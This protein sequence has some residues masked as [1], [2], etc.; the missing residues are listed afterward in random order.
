MR[1][2]VI[3][4]TYT[5]AGLLAVFLL[6]HWLCSASLKYRGSTA[7]R[8]IVCFLFIS[9]LSIPVLGT[10]VSS[11]YYRYILNRASYVLMGYLMYFG[12][13]LLIATIIKGIVWI[14]RHKKADSGESGAWRTAS[15]LV[16]AAIIAVTIALNVYGTFHAKDTVVTNYGVT[17][18]KEVKKMKRLRVAHIS[19]L[20]LSYNSDEKM[21]RRMVE[22]VNA[23]KP[24]VVFVTGDMFTSCYGSLKDPKHYIR[25][26]KKI[27][28]KEGVFWVYGNHDVEEPLF[29]GFGL[30]PPENAIRTKKIERFIKRSGMTILDDECTAIAGGEVQIVGRKDLL[31]PGGGNDSAMPVNELMDD[32]DRAKPILAL[33]HEPVG[34]KELSENGADI[35]FSGHTHNGQVFPGNILTRFWND[36][37]YGM[38][39]RSGMWAEV[40]SGVGFYGPPLRIGTDSEIAVID[41]TF[42]GQ[43]E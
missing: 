18:D 15:A 13:M 14:F 20:H 42:N 17:I 8:V 43:K 31:K 16:L 32:L 30:E 6:D 41:I 2:A 11:E 4:G 5:A 28:A 21:I 7:W 24:D 3:I 10:Y 23:Q 26:L 1:I 27:K 35:A 36:M 25:I 37:V 9:V 19:D 33:V 39:K 38:E 12:G 40:T 34:Y 22:K 29:C